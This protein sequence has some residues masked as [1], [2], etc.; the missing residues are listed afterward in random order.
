MEH[1]S[2]IAQLLLKKPTDDQETIYIRGYF[3]R[4]VAGSGVSLQA[5]LLHV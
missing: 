5:E 2:I 4:R 3:K 1:I